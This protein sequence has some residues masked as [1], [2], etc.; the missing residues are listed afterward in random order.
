[1]S[2]YVVLG[3][4][5]VGATIGARLFE[6]GLE[7]VLI[8]RGEHLAALQKDGLRYGDPERT[9]V[10]AIPTVGDPSALRWGNED[11]VILATKSQASL[12]A[13][14]ALESSA[15]RSVPVVCAQNGVDNE[16]QALRRFPNVY[17]MCVMLPATHLEPGAVDADSFPVVG[18]LDVGRYPEGV[19]ETSRSL[20]GDLDSNGFRSEPDPQVMRW[21][22][23]KLLSNLATA[24]RALCGP[25]NPEEGSDAAAVRAGLVS[26]MRAEALSCYDAAGIV[27]P[28]PEERDR[29]WREITIQPI[30]GRPRAAGSAWQSLARRTGN[31]ES[32]FINGEIVLLGRVHG[33]ATPVNEV[34]QRLAADAARRRLG[35]GTLSPTEVAGAVGRL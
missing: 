7:V 15:P 24:I 14:D 23:E 27:L 33:V 8:A 9:R 18:V 35:P 20:A 30:P 29:R 2:R 22:Y 5:A 16:R 34:V 28:P 1:V 19:D 17:G 12:N 21:K 6:A 32:D 13:L 4:G 26:A 25:E 3:A 11:V 31:V 10:L